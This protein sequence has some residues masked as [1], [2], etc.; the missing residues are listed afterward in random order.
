[1]VQVAV[2]P[3]HHHLEGIVE[4]AQRYRAWHLD[5]PPDQ[6]FDVEQGDFEFVDGQRGFWSGHQDIIECFAW[7]SSDRSG[8]TDRAKGFVVVGEFRLSGLE[9]WYSCNVAFP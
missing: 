3:P 5:S 2:S 6:G 9:S 1:M 7:T 8:V 4:A